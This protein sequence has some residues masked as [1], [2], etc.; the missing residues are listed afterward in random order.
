MSL[1][2]ELVIP[3][4][5]H[6]EE[7]HKVLQSWKKCAGE[8][9]TTTIVDN[10][11]TEEGVTEFSSPIVDRVIAPGRN[12]GLTDSLL[13]SF[14]E[15]DSDI[16]VFTHSDVL[17]WQEDWVHMLKEFFGKDD[18]LG[19]GGAVGAVGVGQDGG[20]MATF[21]RFIGKEWGK[22]SCHEQVWQHHGEWTPDEGIYSATLD[23]CVL[24]VRKSA[25]LEVGLTRFL[26][27][28]YDR[29][30]PLQMW[31]AGYTVMTLPFA[32]DHYSGL[33]ANSSEIYA[34]DGM[35]YITSEGQGPDNAVYLDGLRRWTDKWAY[36][37]PAYANSAGKL[38]WSN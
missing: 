22:C 31:D 12:L 19:M 16:Y 34:R 20:R 33:T 11:S 24:F 5:G 6:F 9:Y 27:H 8:D 21:L 36:R 3:I 17:A 28:W 38:L 26:H 29:E 4:I 37:L 35:K 18:K 10:G 32:C 2:I 15:N 1:K 13:W 23:G 30:W 7:T 25:A 14:E